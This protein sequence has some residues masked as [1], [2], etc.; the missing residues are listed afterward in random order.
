MAGPSPVPPPVPDAVPVRG[1]SLRDAALRVLL[2]SDSPLT[3]TEVHRAL[4]LA[5]FVMLADDPVKKL[6][7][8]LGYE[9]RR[10]VVRRVSR[11]TYTIGTLTPYRRRVLDQAR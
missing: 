2:R 3:L 5:G 7:D 1:R 6:G 4:H 8:A 9:E 10:G 11:G